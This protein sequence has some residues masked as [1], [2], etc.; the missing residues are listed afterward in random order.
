MKIF[1]ERL[2]EQRKLNKLTQRQM[3]E[4]LQITQP[5]YIRYEN[6]TS[7][8]S[9]ESLVKIADH[10]DVSVDYLLGAMNKKTKKWL[11]AAAF[12]T[13]IGSVIFAAIMTSFDWDFSKLSTVNYQKNSH[14]ISEEFS[15]ISIDTDTADITFVLDPEGNSY[16]ACLD[17]ENALHTVDVQNGI[18]TIRQNDE[19][20]WYEYIGFG[21]E[22]PSITVYL[23]QSQ[24]DSLQ[25]NESTGDVL[26]PKGLTFRSINI[27]VST[28][29]V[30]NHASSLEN[31]KIKASTGDIYVEGVTAKSISLSVSTGAVTV[32]DVIC[33]ED[34]TITV[35]TG[36]TNMT[37]VGCKNV[38][39]SGDTGNMI[40]NHVVAAEKLS[41]ERTT[42]DI[43][44]N[45]C[46][47]GEIL[48]KTDT[49]DV[50]GCLLTDK[51]FLAQT[52]T[53]NVDVPKTSTGGKCEISTSTG[54]I[55]III[56]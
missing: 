37:N 4:Y 15:G 2:I 39:S 43:T 22:K 19:R 25:I 52:D 20:E 1:Q 46:D 33:Q 16:V 56:E 48:V 17:I 38:I 8:P 23:S 32:S 31:I 3:A 27:S 10:F 50:T 51:V 13:I 34:V 45:G 9:L 40:L 12:L 55:K 35:S 47:A 26:I 49:G 18:L 11:I 42:G 6:G 28:G 36:K 7:Q 21:V 30:E 44:F 54:D 41:L 5:S 53:G 14:I 29:D 24:Y